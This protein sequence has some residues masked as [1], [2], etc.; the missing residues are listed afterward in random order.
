MT[1]AK[2]KVAVVG[3]GMTGLAAAFYL[4]KQWEQNRGDLHITVIEK[5]D[6]P[7]GKVQTVLRDGFVIE[8]GPD[9]FLAR[10]PEL[11]KLV[12]ELGLDQEL[13][14]LNPHVGAA[15]IL[16]KGKFHPIP[17]GFVM[18]IPTQW[19]PFVTT[20]LLSLRG[21]MRAALDL[22]LP[23]ENIS[24]DMAL[25]EFLERR[26]GKEAVSHIA[27]PLLS[28]IYA[29][30]LYGLSTKATFPQFL[31]LQQKHRS[32]IMA[33]R[34]TRSA[35]V[36]SQLSLPPSVKGSAF[37][38][39]RNG[40]SSIIHALTERLNNHDIRLNA[41]V[42]AIHKHGSGYRLLLNQNERLDAD[43]VIVAV[44]PYA[45]SR[46]LPLASDVSKQL[47][48]IKHASVSNAVLAYHRRPNAAFRG[49]GFLIPRDEGTFMTA[50]TFTS[51]KW[52][53][54]APDG[55]ALI[56]CYVGRAGEEGWTRMSDE[57]IT[58]RVLQ[59]LEQLIGLR[60]K[61]DFSIVTRFER[62]M[63]QYAP[64]HAERMEAIRTQ[65]REDSPGIFLAGAGYGGAGL[66]DCVRQ[67]SDAARSAAEYLK[68]LKK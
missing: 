60:S 64:G 18:G 66:P 59:E 5:N 10:K 37:L 36:S 31:A 44:P 42:T 23:G 67:G 38:H 6:Q 34:Q 7:G 16:H 43:A 52:P 21:K 27:E 20:P 39:M 53:H 19:R 14:G 50:C 3:A 62:A 9:S 68:K 58:D 47:L 13:E 48:D 17:K 45:A 26:L 15:S 25:G 56:R 51:D 8:R 29:G 61:P 55:S 1:I 4:Q 24:E 12:L 46:M 28:G 35:S 30:D 33:M 63:P 32:L 57:E 11:A 40:L 2:F 41:E 65:M 49:T 22:I 54:S